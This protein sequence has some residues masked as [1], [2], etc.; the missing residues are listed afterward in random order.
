MLE[1]ITLSKD[2]NASRSTINIYEWVVLRPP[3]NTSTVP[4]PGQSTWNRQEILVLFLLVGDGEFVFDK[5]TRH[6]A[7]PS[8]ALV[9]TNLIKGDTGK[10]TPIPMHCGWFLK[11][12]GTRVVQSMQLPQM[13]D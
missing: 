1:I 2:R 10:L 4:F 9:V 7:R 8:D 6:D 12:D 5:S 11:T 3:A 13:G